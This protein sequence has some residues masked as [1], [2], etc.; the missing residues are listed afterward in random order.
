MIALNRHIEALLLENECVIVPDFGG[1]MTHHVNSRYDD[2]D[3]SFLPPLRTLGF[4]PQLRMNDSVLVQSYVEAYDISYPEALRK[5]EQEVEELKLQLAENGSYELENLGLLT[6]NQEGNYLFTPTEA[7]VLS[8]EYY[9]LGSFFFKELKDKATEEV[10]PAA[11]IKVSTMEEASPTQPT[12]LEFTDSDSNDSNEAVSI[13]MSWIRNTVAVAAAVIA[14]F[15]IS[16]PITNSNL[17]NQSMSDIQN[18]LLFKILPKDTNRIPAD[19]FATDKQ[20]EEADAV[21]A[22]D[23]TEVEL[24]EEPASTDAKPAEEPASE[25]PTEDAKPT[26][27]TFNYCIVLASQVKESNARIFVNQ[28]HQKGYADA[29]VYTHNKIVRV[30]CGEYA[31]EAEAYSRLKALSG[32]D[33]FEDAWVYKKKS[34]I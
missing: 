27:P 7:G 18:K 34:G 25:E 14:F 17:G 21:A 11:D 24:T 6:V 31:T 19:S 28:L 20:E 2:A 1:F 15:L 33:G 5:I 32:K 9:G 12:L 8:P 16:T 30:I 4:N 13:K 10:Q 26:E 22:D 29:K 23:N 3:H